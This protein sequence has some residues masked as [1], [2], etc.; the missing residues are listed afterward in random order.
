MAVQ[1]KMAIVT[2]ANSGMGLAT[3]VE[4]ARQGAQVIMACRSRS[5]GEEALAEAKRRSGSDKI[6]L[7]LCDLGSLESIRRFAE[8]FQAQ[9]DRLDILINNAGVVMLKREL[10]KDGFEMDLGVNHLG[11]FLLTMLLLD[12]LKASAG[13]RI[14]V[15]GSGAYKI[16]SMDYTD[17][18]MENSFN[19]AKAYGR[20]KLANI[21][22]TKELAVRLKG[23]RVTVNCVH[24]GAVGTSLGV[25]RD[26]G[27]GKSV[28]KLLSY[29]F[30]TPEK[31]ADTALYLATSPE[32]E[33]VTGQYFYRR[34]VQRLTAR[35]DDRQAA[36][37]F[38]E[39]SERQV[40][41]RS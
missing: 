34:K 11:H 10:T 28:L 22:F 32:V 37:K 26:T 25:N 29:F 40:G 3:T 5:R 27:F 8:Q 9:Y 20:S 36:R 38:W 24:P 15:V 2:G 31:G 30:Q 17:P 14:V 41:L 16:G 35:A 18:A 1:G 4:L 19:P 39:W 23:T 13:A 6:E 33:G 7:M 21:W 12:A